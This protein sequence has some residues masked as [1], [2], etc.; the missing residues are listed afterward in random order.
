M[1]I[2]LFNWRDIK[3]PAKGGAEI[4]FHEMAKLWVKNGHE[5]TMIC[6]GWKNCKKEE[7]VDSIKIKR[8]GNFLTLY[9]LA[10][11]AY[12]GLKEKPDVVVDVENGIPF[13][14]PIFVKKSKRFLHIHHIHREVWFKQLTFP[15]SFIGWFME[16]QVL[17][18]VYKKTPVITI[19]ES[20]KKEIMEAGIG[21][22]I[23]VVNPGIT[24]SKYKHYKK[25]ELPSIL[26]LNRIKKYKGLD[27]LLKAVKKMN[28]L[29]NKIKVF[30]AGDGDWLNNAKS[31]ANEHKLD[32]VEFFGRV[33][34]AKKEELIQ[35][36]WV[37]INPSLKEGWGI[38]NIESNYMGTPAIGSD[39]SGI[40]DSI[41]DGKTGVIFKYGDSN[42]L[43]E[44]IKSIIDNKKLR[45]EMSRN[46]IKWAKRFSWDSAAKKYMEILKK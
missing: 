11:F 3:N 41:V 33:S 45:Q 46:A 9:F 6:G 37:F 23:G 21:K 18:I 34:E 10:P 26:F 24:F 40:K 44:K 35:K 2:L 13:F 39:V 32:N 7:I 29:N 38:I 19:S 14:T 25:T 42:E 15:F 30:V 17:P 27:I 20:S 31:Y 28:T 8:V 4:Y 43:A 1:K 16:M 36:S 5:V 22:V 12:L